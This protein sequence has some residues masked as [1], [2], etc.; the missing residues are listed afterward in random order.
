MSVHLLTG[1]LLMF[2]KTFIDFRDKGTLLKVFVDFILFFFEHLL[3]LVLLPYV[4]PLQKGGITGS[5]V[6]FVCTDYRLK[7][8]LYV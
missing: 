7:S 3:D 6:A 1:I 2:F 4:H 8:A 5:E